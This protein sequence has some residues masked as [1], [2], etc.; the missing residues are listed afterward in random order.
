MD[1]SKLSPAPWFANGRQLY[2]EESF[3]SLVFSGGGFP[4]NVEFCALARNAF[5]VMIRRKWG[6][7]LCL[8]GGWEVFSRD[9]QECRDLDCPNVGH[10]DPFT[11]LVEAD[12]WYV[13]NVEN[14]P[15]ARTPNTHPVPR[16]DSRP[17]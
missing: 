13:A 8:I 2:G 10:A 7:A 5:D 1:L 4:T 11:A 16:P 6:V 14:Q 3:S 9:G 15:H 17:E 12:R